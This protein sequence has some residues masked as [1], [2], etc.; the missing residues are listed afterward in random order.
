MKVLSLLVL[1]C[2]CLALTA[3]PINAS[4]ESSQLSSQERVKGRIVVKLD[5][6]DAQL[7]RRASSTESGS[8]GI[9]S[10]D[11][12]AAEYRVRDIDPMFPGAEPVTYRDR[13]IDL[14]RYYIVRFDEDVDLDAIVR[15]YQ[16]DPNV[17]LAE[18]AAVGSVDAT[19]NDPKFPDQWHLE[20][21]SDFDI[22]APEAWDIETGDS[23]II[24][25]ILDAGIRY[26]HKDLG[27]INASNENPE[28]ARGNMWVNYHEL[29]E[30]GGQ[31]G[32]DDDYNGWVDDWIGW[33]FI[34]GD[35]NP[36]PTD[37]WTHGTQVAGMV[38]AINNNGLG[39][40]SVGGGW[41]DG[42]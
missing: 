2:M 24:V 4:D 21:A 16:N 15:A 41:N 39:V 18:A 6:Y 9:A 33:D 19:P 34:E 42:S 23:A 20:Q 25:A 36:H 17:E 13:V 29:P 22:N 14:S 32:V 1:A 12:I 35:N 40:S 30:N 31:E 3:P 37:T 28:A 26:Y 5:M 11:A 38:A 7:E 27:G 10:L 8:V